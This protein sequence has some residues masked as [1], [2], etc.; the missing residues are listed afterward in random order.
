MLFCFF[1]AKQD[2][3]IYLIQVCVVVSALLDITWLFYGLENFKSVVIRNTIVKL[4]ECVLIFTL[5]KSPEDLWI[6]TVIMGVSVCLG[7]VIMFPQALRIAKPLVPKLKD[8]IVHLKPLLLLFIAV[9]ASTLYTVFDKTLLGLLQNDISNV[10]YYDYSDKII[11]I[12]KQL[13]AVIGTVM[14]PRACKNFADNKIDELKKS[15][16]ISME[17]VSLISCG[18]IF[19][20]LV[21]G[22]KFAVLYYGQDFAVCGDVIRYMSPLILIVMLGDILRSQFII[23]ANK[24]FAY[25]IGMVLSAVINIIV[26]VI[27][28]PQIGIMG[29]VIGTTLAEVVGF[30]YQMI[31]SKSVISFFDLLKIVLPFIVDGAIMFAGLWLIDIYTPVSYTSLIIEFLIGFLMYA[32]IAVFTIKIFYKDLWKKLFGYFGKKNKS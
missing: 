29:A 13:I 30:V 3:I 21:I 11:T 27:L 15:L 4:V 22:G 18:C 32:V 6:Y 20:L 14:F 25:V 19:G 9:V 23:P 10:A 1:I 17:I 7:Q 31:Q 8:M 16:S 24:D 2:V 28:I 12:P 26:S 5:V